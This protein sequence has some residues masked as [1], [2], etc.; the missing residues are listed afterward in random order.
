MTTTKL[1]LVGELTDRQLYRLAALW[2][3]A[4]HRRLEPD[5]L[6]GEADLRQELAL[7]L[8]VQRTKHPTRPIR[9]VGWA[10]RHEAQVLGT[11]GK[12]AA[13]I[14]AQVRRGPAW[15]GATKAEREQMLLAA[16]RREKTQTRRPA[17]EV[18]FEHDPES[19]G[20]RPDV[21]ATSN[22]LRD[23]L[24]R[25]IHLE[26]ERCGFPSGDRAPRA[27]AHRLLDA[28]VAG[29]DRA[30]DAG[31]PPRSRSEGLRILR[32]ATARAAGGHLELAELP[33]CIR[34]DPAEESGW[35]EPDDDDWLD[36]IA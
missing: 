20:T 33:G 8:S 36:E 5:I 16:R 32:R 24:V 7:R 31:L 10:L 19:N 14:D 28:F 13:R 1:P 23:E 12:R 4:W 26:I 9:S 18:A 11:R 17:A 30:K 15:A 27:A 25:R 22:A 2:A 3:G 35:P 6:L 29:G 34:L 21:E